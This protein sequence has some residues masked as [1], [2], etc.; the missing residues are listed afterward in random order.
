MTVKNQD[1]AV[2]LTQDLD[3][4][5]QEV[6]K[7]FLAIMQSSKALLLP[8]ENKKYRTVIEV[9]HSRSGKETNL[10]SEFLCFFWNM[11][12]TTNRAG[13]RMI[14]F[15][16]DKEALSKFGQ[17]LYNRA[18]RQVYKQTMFESS[19]INIEDAV[20]ISPELTKIQPFFINRMMNGENDFTSIEIVENPTI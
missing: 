9:Q 12:L 16:Y 5:N 6:D 17:R 11:T 3:K 4:R 7:A 18:I 10:K 1:K 20:R 14:Y 2:E 19:E 15:N 13:Y 8:F